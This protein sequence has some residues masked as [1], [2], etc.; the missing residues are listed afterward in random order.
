MVN[1]LICLVDKNIIKVNNMYSLSSVI[2][3][4][5]FIYIDRF[6]RYNYSKRHSFLCIIHKN[7]NNRFLCFNQNQKYVCGLVLILNKAY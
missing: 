3:H 5:N 1:I 4:F 6:L 7:E 2:K